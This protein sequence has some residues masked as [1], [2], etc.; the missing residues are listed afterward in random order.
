VGLELSLCTRCKD[1][2]V[3]LSQLRAPNHLSVA[4]AGEPKDVDH[5]LGYHN[6]GPLHALTTRGPPKQLQAGKGQD[7]AAPVAVKCPRWQD[8]TWPLLAA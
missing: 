7:M 2:G 1:R 3:H 5:A 4:V 6:I 8:C